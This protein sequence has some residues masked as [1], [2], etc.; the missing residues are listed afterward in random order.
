MEAAI[1]VK[2]FGFDRVFRFPSAPEEAPPA[3]VDEAIFQQRIASLEADIAR[4]RAEHIEILARARSDA[5]AAGLAQARSERDAAV[6][7]AC[8]ALHATLD[9]IDA[10]IA[11]ATEAVM[12]DAAK[13]AF[14]AAEVLAGHAVEQAPARAAD[15]ALGRV[16]D[17]VSRGTRIGIRVHPAIAEDMERL[18][19]VRVSKERRKLSLTVIADEEMAESDA[20]IF[21]EEGGLAVDAAHRRAAILAE[22]GPLLGETKDN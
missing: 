14:T 2:P 9:D 15:E 5:F 7:A 10:R 21:W 8:D 4:L 22:L 3:S 20:L 16:L 11:Q 18:I 12:K 1:H 6:L 19:A 17:Q 13:L